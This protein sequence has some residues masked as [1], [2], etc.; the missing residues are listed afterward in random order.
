[1]I[2]TCSKD[3]YIK[4]LCSINEVISRNL[5]FKVIAKLFQQIFVTKCIFTSNGGTV[6]ITRALTRSLSLS[7]SF[8]AL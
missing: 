1:M 8:D 6:H 3:T 4:I 7:E 5:I 2:K